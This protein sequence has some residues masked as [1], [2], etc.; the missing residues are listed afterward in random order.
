MPSASSLLDQAGAER[1]LRPH[2]DEVDRLL[3]AEGSQSHRRSPWGRAYKRRSPRRRRSMPAH[4]GPVSAHQSPPS[5]GRRRKLPAEG[6]FAPAGAHDQD[7]H[8][9]LS[10]SANRGVTIHARASAGARFSCRFSRK[11]RSP[12]SR[13]TCVSRR[14]P[15]PSQ[16]GRRR[17][18]PVRGHVRA[19]RSPRPCDVHGGLSNSA[20]RGVTIHARAY[21]GAR[22]S[23]R[24]SRNFAVFAA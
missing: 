13:C 5:S 20:N 3:A 12:H 22:F 8:G 9:G 2:H 17:K 15:E 23:C 18:L 21:A 16:Q 7:V 10:N 11:R 1:S 19:R 24:F 14:A 4:F 6:M